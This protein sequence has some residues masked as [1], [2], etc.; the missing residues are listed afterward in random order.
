[1][2]AGFS[3]SADDLT[4]AQYEPSEEELEGVAAG[5]GWYRRGASLLE[6]W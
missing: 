3:M 2:E 1:M 6:S 4:K 5:C